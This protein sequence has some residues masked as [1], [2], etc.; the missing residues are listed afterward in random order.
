MRNETEGREL[1]IGQASTSEESAD[2]KTPVVILTDAMVDACYSHP[3][4]IPLPGKRMMRS[5]L[6]R[7]LKHAKV[8]VVDLPYLHLHTRLAS[9]YLLKAKAF[10]G[11][12]WIGSLDEALNHVDYVKTALEPHVSN[13]P[14]EPPPN[15]KRLFEDA[16]YHLRIVSGSRNSFTSDATD[17]LYDLDQPRINLRT[18]AVEEMHRQAHDFIKAHE[19]LISEER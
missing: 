9:E 3:E 19:H 13:E 5:T 4:K 11:H 7:A 16:M 12:R 17:R 10:L 14:T 15:Y 2:K 1:Q 8:V 6:E 18:P